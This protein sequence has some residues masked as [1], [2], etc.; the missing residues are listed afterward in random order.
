MELA[1]LLAG[2]RFSD[3]PESVCPVIAAF[4]RSY[5]D[6]VDDERRQDLYRFAAASVG[7]R[8][9]GRAERRRARLALRWAVER[10]ALGRGR[11]PLQQSIAMTH[12]PEEAGRVAGRVAVRLVAD[13]W[14]GV[15]AAALAFVERLI[16]E[17]VPG[18]SAE[19]AARRATGG[20][21]R[22][23]CGT[24]EAGASPR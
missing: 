5:N 16:G 20:T 18:T 17:P 21:L 24:R 8:S 15:H 3:H 2:E 10:Q 1:S 23:E 11:G 6:G 22:A 9:T 13:G 12:G 14:P 7:T 19:Q 4:L